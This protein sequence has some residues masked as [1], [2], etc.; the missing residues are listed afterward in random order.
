MRSTTLNN[1]ALAAKRK[2][3]TTMGVGKIAGVAGEE[4]T[5]TALA[6]CAGFVLGCHLGSY[7]LSS[8]AI[9]AMVVVLVHIAGDR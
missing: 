3:T 2:N 8:V 4:W 9:V 5:R 6:V 1:T 7:F